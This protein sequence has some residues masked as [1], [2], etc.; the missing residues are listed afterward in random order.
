ML[1]KIFI[2]LFLTANNFSSYTSS[3][4]SKEGQEKNAKIYKISKD[5]L[6]VLNLDFYKYLENEDTEEFKK[7]ILL[8][9]IV[10]KMLEKEGKKLKVIKKPMERI[11][12]VNSF[13]GK[14]LIYMNINGSVVFEGNVKNYN[15]LQREIIQWQGIKIIEPIG[16]KKH[17]LTNI[18]R[19]NGF[20]ILSEEET[21]KYSLHRIIKKGLGEY[22]ANDVDEFSELNYKS[23]Y[24]YKGTQ[25]GEFQTYKNRDGRHTLLYTIL[26]SDGSCWQIASDGKTLDE[27]FK[28]IIIHIPS[29]QPTEEEMRR[30]TFG[31][32][33]E[34][35]RYYNF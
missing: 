12:P 30:T 26:T 18:I 2:L 31:K 34:D 28:K 4:F 5:I 19:T 16:Y 21:I 10:E 11:Y 25:I 27:A 7:G 15:F 17:S 8:M 14:K 35:E 33:I 13:T 6:S 9:D 24:V 3:S 23:H 1:I 22:I 29:S 32:R 20:S